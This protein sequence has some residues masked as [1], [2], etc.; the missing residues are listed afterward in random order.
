MLESERIS[1]IFLVDTLL[2]EVFSLMLRPTVKAMTGLRQ[3]RVAM[4]F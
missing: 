3:T 1:F 4:R 2:L